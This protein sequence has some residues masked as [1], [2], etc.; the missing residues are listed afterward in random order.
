MSYS[1][2][3]NLGR[4]AIAK[5]MYNNC[6]FYISFGII[7]SSYID[8]WDIDETVPAYV[9]KQI[10]NEIITRTANSN[11]DYVQNKDIHTVLEIKKDPT[12][13]IGVLNE[14]LNITAVPGVNGN[15]KI[16]IIPGGFAGNETIIFSNGVLSVLLENSVTTV[17]QLAN[18]LLT[19]SL[20]RSAEVLTNQNDTLTLGIKSDTVYL[21]GGANEIVYLKDV[22]YNIG[23]SSNSDTIPIG[24]I[25]WLTTTKPQDGLQYKIS[26]WY[27]SVLSVQDNLIQ[28][29]GFKKAV[30]KIYVIEDENGSIR[31]NDKKWSAS[32]VPTR[33]VALQFYIDNADI[34]QGTVVRQVGLYINTIP[35]DATNPNHFYSLNELTSQG[36]LLVIENLTPFVHEIISSCNFT[37]VLSF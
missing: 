26:Y 33:H 23:T 37:I 35:T 28:V 1:S 19:H 18:I 3:T 14:I 16:N 21:V 4:T 13:A 24:A 31:A 32:L 25:K 36:E 27:K 30:S 10:N 5:Q 11:L 9:A 7:P 29:F 2:L 6:D 20:I 8:K 12:S 15:I 17:Q 22:D 34:E